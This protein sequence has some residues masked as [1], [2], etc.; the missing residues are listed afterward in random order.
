MEKAVRSF[1]ASSVETCQ[2]ES[3]QKEEKVLLWWLPHEVVE[4]PY[5]QGEEKSHI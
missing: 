2:T 1:A 4:Q 5:G 3:G